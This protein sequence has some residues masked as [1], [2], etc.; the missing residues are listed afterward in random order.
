VALSLPTVIQ[1]SA[2]KKQMPKSR[3]EM[4]DLVWRLLAEYS[5]F[6]RSR[7]DLPQGNLRGLSES[8]LEELVTAFQIDRARKADQDPPA[9]NRPPY[10]H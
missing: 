2:R 1:N 8:E 10:I 9:P 5:E 3:T 7:P 4:M 6:R